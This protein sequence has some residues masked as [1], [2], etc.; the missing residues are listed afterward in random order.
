MSLAEFCVSSS[1]QMRLELL[2]WT[3][4]YSPLLLN[5]VWTILDIFGG[6]WTVRVCEHSTVSDP[7]VP[8]GHWAEAWLQ[9]GPN[10]V[11][12]DVQIKQHLDQKSSSSVPAWT[13]SAS[14]L[15]LFL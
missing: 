7:L 11:N 1:T 4:L 9:K 6:A 8:V 12:F 2:L 13:K 3:I 5:V 10:D 15:S 14:V